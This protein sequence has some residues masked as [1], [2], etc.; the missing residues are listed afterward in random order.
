MASIVA[1][2]DSGGVVVGGDHA[3][4]LPPGI[5]LSQRAQRDP[6]SWGRLGT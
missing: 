5:L 3:D 4:R 6:G 1:H 2:M